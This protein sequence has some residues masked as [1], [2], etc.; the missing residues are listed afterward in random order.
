MRK[1]EDDIDELKDKIETAQTKINAENRS[2]S[3]N[4]Q[5]I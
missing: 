4:E 2:P 5:K 3:L 1:L